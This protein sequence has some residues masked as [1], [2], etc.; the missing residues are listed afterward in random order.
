MCALTHWFAVA[1]D[2]PTCSD[3]CFDESGTHHGDTHLHGCIIGL[4]LYGGWVLRT[5][6]F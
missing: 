4:Q 1:T 3:L 2:P 6:G 5:E